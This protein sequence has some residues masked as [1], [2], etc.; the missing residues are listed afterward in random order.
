MDK[1]RSRDN[2]PVTISLL[3]GRDSASRLVMDFSE[4]R[5]PQAQGVMILWLSEN[6][7]VNVETSENLTS[8][9]SL[10]LLGMAQGLLQGEGG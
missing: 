7:S 6:G 2:K 5:L 4:H 8:L 10:G 1:F 9:E 3:L